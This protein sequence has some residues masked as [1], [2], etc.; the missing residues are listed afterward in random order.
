MIQ[1]STNQI[2][3]CVKGRSCCPIVEK[4]DEDTFTISDDYNGQVKLTKN[5]FVMLQEAIEKLSN[6]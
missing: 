1:L 4:V 3:L 2:K 6:I 5:E